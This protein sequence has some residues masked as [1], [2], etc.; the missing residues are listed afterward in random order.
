M[1][2]VKRSVIALLTLAILIPAVIAGS[3]K[4]IGAHNDKAKKYSTFREI[5]DVTNEEIAAIEALR[6]EYTS[7]VYGMNP[8]TEAFY[9][10]YGVI[11]GYTALICGWLTELFGIPFE[12]ELYEW[13]DLVAG[14]ET[15]E[16]DFTGEL[17][18]TAERQKTYFMTNAIAERSVKIM[19][20]NDSTPLPE[21]AETRGLRYAF[22]EG[23]TNVEQVEPLSKYEFE[24]I[25]LDDYDTV[26][27]ML[28]NGEIDAFF[29][30]CP[31][32]AAFDD[33]NDFAVQHFFPL[34]YSSVSLTTLNHRLA[35]VISIVQKA[36]ENGAL[37]YLSDL[38]NQGHEEYMKYKLSLQLTM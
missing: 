20:I 32:E 6:V 12:P 29:D 10:K 34:I 23:S 31:A 5:P 1:K 2:T 8:G 13:G 3:A 26:Y 18:A 21:I 28:K 16:I 27:A 33:Y 38:Y 25:Y 11:R 9:N 19:R 36:L 4:E 17:T 22:L 14:L 24:T 37:H 15:F 7:F 35:P 30:E